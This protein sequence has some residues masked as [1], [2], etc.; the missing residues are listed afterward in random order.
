MLAAESNALAV[1]EL[2]ERP[3][4][5]AALEMARLSIRILEKL[6]ETLRNLSFDEAV[7][8]EQY[9]TGYREGYAACKADR[10]RLEVVNGRR[11]APGP[12]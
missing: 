5:D 9:D 6:G 3:G 1:R 2:A 12:H 4:D 11:A 10:C 8:A 7:F